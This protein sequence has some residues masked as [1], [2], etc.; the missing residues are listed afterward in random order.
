MLQIP[1][2][3]CISCKKE[4]SIHEF[5]VCMKNIDHRRQKCKVCY[6]STKSKSENEIIAKNT[7]EVGFFRFKN[8]RGLNKKSPRN[9]S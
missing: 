6:N 5:P 3:V 4:I 7:G 8:R 9:S 2:K 1:K